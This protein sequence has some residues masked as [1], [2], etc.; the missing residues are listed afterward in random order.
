MNDV[1]EQIMFLMQTGKAREAV[2]KIFELPSFREIDRLRNLWAF[3]YENND[4]WVTENDQELRRRRRT[5]LHNLQRVHPENS[6][7]A[8]EIYNGLLTRTSL[9]EF[10][11]EMTN[12]LD[13]LNRRAAIA[14]NQN[15]R[16]QLALLERQRVNKLNETQ[17]LEQ[18]AQEPQD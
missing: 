4:F 8:D 2:A 3:E 1:V 5:I 16:M 18:D 12:Q 11:V 9:T 7:L 13:F 6:G 14:R 15:E 17:I 10:L